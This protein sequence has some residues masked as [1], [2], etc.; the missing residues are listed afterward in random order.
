MVGDFGRFS[1]YRITRWLVDLEP[2]GEAIALIGVYRRHNAMFVQPLVNAAL[3]VGWHT[4]WWA[5]DE[6]AEEL[7][8]HTVGC[9]EGEKF[10][11]LNELVRRFEFDDGWVVVAD[12]DFVFVRGGL[13]E[14]VSLSARA[15][16]ALAQPAH[17]A[18]SEIS[19]EIT[20]SRSLA[21]ARR[22]NFVEIGPIFVVAPR[23]RD[24]VLPFPPDSGMGWGLELEWS[25]LLK[26]GCD[27][28]VVDVVAIKH[29]GVVASS[30]D[31]DIQR[32]LLKDKLAARGIERWRDTHRTLG[33]WRPWQRQPGWKATGLK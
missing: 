28:G 5:L 2:P 25:D 19:H 12:D 22:T 9:G 32:R 23:C 4:A 6:P 13:V 18:G 14:F 30:Y 7:S 33:I 10:T 1:T 24:D 16:F 29:I 8:L 21:V 20:L 27:I 3:A 15:G 11:L 26:R 17:V 31:A